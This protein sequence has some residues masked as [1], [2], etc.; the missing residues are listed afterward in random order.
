MVSEGKYSSDVMT[1]WDA[2]VS[3]LRLAQ[4]GHV[5]DNEHGNPHVCHHGDHEQG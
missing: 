4:C 5:L 2:Y 3:Y 1:V